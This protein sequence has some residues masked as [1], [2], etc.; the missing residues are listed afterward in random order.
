MFAFLSLLS[1]AFRKQ[2][3]DVSS[4]LES[5][6]S[7]NSLY[8][9]T[10]ASYI[11]GESPHLPRELD[12]S[13]GIARE[14]VPWKYFLFLRK[15]L[16]VP[17]SLHLTFN[18]MI[19]SPSSDCDKGERSAGVAEEVWRQSTGS[20]GDE[21]RRDTL[22]PTRR[23]W[24]MNLTPSCVSD[25]AHYQPPNLSSGLSRLRCQTRPWL[26]GDWIAI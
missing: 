21:V 12:H 2:H 23:H 13:L 7:K 14:E 25:S 8:S 1:F 17:L 19:L 10:T 24:S 15:S 5:G 3:R 16:F 4:S 22:D 26:T 11:E 20:G 6:V 18:E 9:R